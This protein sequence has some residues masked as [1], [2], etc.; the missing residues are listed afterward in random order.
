MGVSA[1]SL[2]KQGGNTTVHSGTPH[3]PRKYNYACVQPFLFRTKQSYCFQSC[4]KKV[5]KQF[6]KY[7]TA[8]FHT[9]R[10]TGT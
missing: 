5:M 9:K 8:M 3:K 7:F 10:V 4:I 1:G 2:Y 6:E